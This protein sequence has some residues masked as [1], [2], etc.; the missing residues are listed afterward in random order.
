MKYTE[1]N[2]KLVKYFYDFEGM[3]YFTGIV[4]NK[5]GDI[6]YFLNGYIHRVDGPA[7]KYSNGDIAWYLNNL[8][9]IVQFHFSALL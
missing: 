7:I 8:L 6:A 5:D 3:E 4:K 9:P 2:P 1:D